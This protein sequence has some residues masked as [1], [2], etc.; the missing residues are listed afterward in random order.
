MALV[1]ASCDHEPPVGATAGAA[2]PACGERLIAIATSEELVGQVIEGRFQIVAPLGKG[3]MGEVYRARQLSIGRDVALKVLDRRIER[4]V[5]AVKRFFRE[6]KLA[7]TLAHPNTVPIIDF[8]QTAEGRLYLVMELVAGHTLLDELR[9]HGAMPLP[10]IVA[11]GSQ[12]CDALEVA[13]DQGIVHRDLKPENIMLLAGRRDHV[14]ILDFGLARSVDDQSQRATATGLISGTP[15][16][17][18]PEVAYDAAPPAPSQD[19]Y[20]IGVILGE[21][22]LGRPL[23]SAA[24]IEALFTKKLSVDDAVAE[25]PG[26]LRPLVRR[27]IA[28]EPAERPTAAETRERLHD[29]LRAPAPMPSLQIELDPVA[30]AKPARPAPVAFSEL[31]YENTTDIA[32]PDLANARLV[33]LDELAGDA[34]PAPTPVARA[35]PVSADRFQAPPEPAAKLELDDNWV[36]ARSQKLPRAVQPVAIVAPPAVARRG[37]MAMFLVLLAIGGVVL[38]VLLGVV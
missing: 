16:Y 33:G 5:A 1:C 13:H 27:L 35:T 8:G 37:G 20:A 18:A 9:D 14:K 2:C 6:A 3:G 22:A 25:V 28:T 24:T 21:L 11:I 31:A 38:C 34:A 4:D 29:A 7:S 17:M 10:R 36:R 12:L 19:L 23:W 32:F 30:P 15:R 26:A